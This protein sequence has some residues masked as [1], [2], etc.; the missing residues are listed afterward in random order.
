MGH[1]AT[2]RNQFKSMNA[3]SEIMIIYFIKQAQ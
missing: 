1:I 2:L 3:L